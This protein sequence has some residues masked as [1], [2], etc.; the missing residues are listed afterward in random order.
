MAALASLRTAG[1]GASREQGREVAFS[2][3]YGAAHE[4]TRLAPEDPRAQRILTT[5]ST[6][7]RIT[8]F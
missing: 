7:R 8:R 1:D 5:V 4:L 3:F 2:A 6:S